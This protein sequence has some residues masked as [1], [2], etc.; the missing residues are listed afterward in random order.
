MTIWIAIGA[1]ATACAAF[2]TAG[3]AVFT[4]RMAK[5]TKKSAKAA[6]DS[7][8]QAGEELEVLKRQTNGIITQVKVAQ[9]ALAQGSTPVLIP[10]VSDGRMLEMPDPVT[11]EF[12]Q[13]QFRS[14]NR[15]FIQHADKR[16][17][18]LVRDPND[19][20]VVWLIIELQ[21]AGTGLAVVRDPAVQFTDGSLGGEFFSDRLSALVQSPASKALWPQQPVMAPGA[22]AFFVRAIDYSGTDVW[23]L[24]T[25]QEN[26][27]LPLKIDT[28]FCYRD[29]SC[30]RQYTMHVSYSV[31]PPLGDISSAL[32]SGSVD[33]EGYEMPEIEIMK[34]DL[35]E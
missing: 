13:L 20:P 7:V 19:S 32:I 15:T 23:H 16:G 9:Q 30:A 35:R 17:S 21:N 3:A 6:E 4:A 10:V 14:G 24:L 22:N 11:G 34:G 5:E 25:N 18:R 29:L 31:D 12:S 1:I 2:A 33:F 26:T 27:N 8:A 28:S